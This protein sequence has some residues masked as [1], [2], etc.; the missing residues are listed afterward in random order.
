[1]RAAWLLILLVGCVPPPVYRVQRA[2]RMPRPAVPLR[3]GE[4]LAGPVE[5]SF[6]AVAGKEA[7][8]VDQEAAIEVPHQ[9]YRGELRVRIGERGELAP[10]YE[11][12]VESSMDKLDATQAPINSGTPHALGV[13]MRYSIATGVPGLSIGTAADVMSWS[14]PY[15]EYRT[16]VEY[17]EENGVY[18]TQMLTGT[19]SIGT[20]GVGITPTYRSGHFAIFGGAYTRRHPTIERKGTEVGPE[21]DRDITAGNFNLM[22]HAGVEFQAAMFSVMATVQQDLTPDPVQYGPSLGFAIALHV[23]DI[24]KT[25]PPPPPPPPGPP[26]YIPD[27]NLPDDPW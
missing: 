2:A 19:E 14:V 3:T 27:E 10:F 12:A 21:V 23:P 1:M 22:L 25:P 16:C 15:V 17:C 26:S 24:K 9:Q 7:T 18:G 5:V 6:G 4:P 13:A 20:F 11:Q 8:L